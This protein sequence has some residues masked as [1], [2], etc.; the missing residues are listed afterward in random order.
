MGVGLVSQH[1]RFLAIRPLVP[2]RL[3]LSRHVAVRQV[4]S[5]VFNTLGG[6][7]TAFKAQPL[8]LRQP[9]EILNPGVGDLRVVEFQMSEVGQPLEMLKSG[10]GNLRR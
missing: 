4:L 5:Q 6:D 3:G 7:L 9:L 1:R 10:V 2:L 8:K